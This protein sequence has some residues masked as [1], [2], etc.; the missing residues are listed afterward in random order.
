MYYPLFFTFCLSAFAITSCCCLRSLSRCQNRV[1]R[2]LQFV[3]VTTCC[4]SWGQVASFSYT[5]SRHE[6]NQFGSVRYHYRGSSDLSERDSSC[7]RESR[8][9]KRETSKKSLLGANSNGECPPALIYS[10]KPVTTSGSQTKIQKENS[11]TSF[12]TVLRLKERKNKNI[13]RSLLE[14]FPITGLVDLRISKSKSE[15]K[16][17]RHQPKKIPPDRG[18]TFPALLD[19]LLVPINL[20][21]SNEI[22]L[23]DFPRRGIFKNQISGSLK[24]LDEYLI[25]VSGPKDQSS[26]VIRASCELDDSHVW[27]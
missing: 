16:I 14:N 18:K 19:A 2:A 12:D 25:D 6:R 4:F 15:E 1:S 7:F 5:S 3:N 21:D 20:K 9:L 24:S 26:R 10:P 22:P 11:S 13:T 23:S 27:L 8:L 17:L